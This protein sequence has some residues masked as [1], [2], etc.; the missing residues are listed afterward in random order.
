[1]INSN[2]QKG[3]RLLACAFTAIMLVCAAGAQTTTAT[4]GGVVA[5]PTGAVIPNATVLVKN[6]ATGDTR[7]SVSN[8]A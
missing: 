4:L 2:L 7:T 5:D 6:E 1:M 3:M 8:G